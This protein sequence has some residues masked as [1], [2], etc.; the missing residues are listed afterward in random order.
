MQKI[1][2]GSVEFYITNVCNFNC[3]NCNRLNNYYFSGHQLWKDYAD[4]YHTWSQKIDLVEMSIL[5]GEPLLNPSLMEWIT[6]LKRLWPAAKLHVLSNGSR[7][8][9]W[10][11]RGLFEL[12]AETNTDLDLFLHNRS[13]R[14]E[15]IE[16]IK[17]Y[18]VNPVGELINNTHVEWAQCYNNVKDPSWPECNTYDDFANLPRHIQQEC[19]EIH[20]I[21]WDDFLQD[22]G[23]YS[24]KDANGVQVFINFA[25]DFLTAPLKYSGADQFNVYHSIP[26]QAHKVCP[27]K[28]CTTMFSG[29]MYKCHHMALLPEFSKQYNVVMTNDQKTLLGSYQPLLPQDELEVMD[30]FIKNLRHTMPQC[31]LCPSSLDVTKLTSS[32]DKPKVKKLIPIKVS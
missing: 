17:N 8:E 30:N 32:T 20:K 14:K 19:V 11:K 18:L 4:A 10:H 9:Y 7:L 2:K 29:K 3:V 5:G 21:G 28:H 26:E 13:R 1:M 25:E 23:I 24:I 12:L 27:S 31:Q 15:I 6:G 16:E 22:T